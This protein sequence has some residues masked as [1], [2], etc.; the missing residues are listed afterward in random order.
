MLIP[1]PSD[2]IRIA[3]IEI[4]RRVFPLRKPYVLSFVTLNEYTS[5]LATITTEQGIRRSAEVVPLPGYSDESEEDILAYLAEESTHLEGLSLC[6]AR[7]LVAKKTARQPF[8]T[9]PLLTAIDLFDWLPPDTIEKRSMVLPCSTSTPEEVQSAAEQ[10]LFSGRTLKIKLSGDPDRDL[11]GLAALK[12]ITIREVR[13]DANQAYDYD[14]AT[15]LIG[16]LIE[17]GIHEKLAY[18]EQPFDK[19]E[20]GAAIR[21]NN[22]HPEIPVM[23]DETVITDSDVQR[24]CDAG[25]KFL[26]LKLFKQGGIRETLRQAE[27][28]HQSGVHVIMGNGVATHLANDIENA[29]IQQHASWFWGD[30]EANG[31]EKLA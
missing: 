5:I 7:T 6:A 23:L 31:F 13:L 8:S 1:E 24:A 19:E 4:D 9:S 16:G 30:S 11:T 10:A 27:A 26:K 22:C 3:R 18:F 21:L 17:Y 15:K 25:F 28:A 29:L 14:S 20:W 2:E 12:S